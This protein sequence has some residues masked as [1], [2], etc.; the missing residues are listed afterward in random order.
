MNG[1]ALAKAFG[2][3]PAIRA[4]PLAAFRLGSVCNGQNTNPVQGSAF[5]VR[6]SRFS[7]GPL[8]LGILGPP[9]FEP[10]TVNLEG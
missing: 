4:L 7:A 5:K 6:A 9:N 1:V 3:A 8:A 2:E 10:G